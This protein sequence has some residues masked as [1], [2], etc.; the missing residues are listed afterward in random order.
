MEEQGEDKSSKIFSVQYLSQTPGEGISW[1]FETTF[2][3]YK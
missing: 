2:S 1:L 3:I